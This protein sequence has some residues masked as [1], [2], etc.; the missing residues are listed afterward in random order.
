MTSH[1]KNKPKSQTELSSL[2]VG[3]DNST[4]WPH[5]S[6]FSIQHPKLFEQKMG[7]IPI[8][9]IILTATKV[10]GKYL[11][12]MPEIVINIEKSRIENNLQLDNKISTLN[13]K[14]IFVSPLIYFSLNCSYDITSDP[15]GRHTHIPMNTGLSKSTSLPSRIHNNYWQHMIYF[16]TKYIPVSQHTNMLQDINTT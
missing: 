6:G 1:I 5:S 3:G 4:P 16:I 8:S 14:V 7:C 15:L 12:S 9:T 2:Q 13:K 11:H 10:S